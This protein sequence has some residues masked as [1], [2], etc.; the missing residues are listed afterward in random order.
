MSR[1]LTVD[2]SPSLLAYLE[3][4]LTA[5]DSVSKEYPLL[6]EFIEDDKELFIRELKLALI[7]AVNDPLEF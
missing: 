1:R 3:V 4:A 5:L 7:N 6:L 2:F